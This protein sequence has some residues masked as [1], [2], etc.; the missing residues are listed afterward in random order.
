MFT[1]ITPRGTIKA[2]LILFILIVVSLKKMRK[3]KRMINDKFNN[4]NRTH[5]NRKKE[6]YLEHVIKLKG[7]PLNYST[8]LIDATRP[9]SNNQILIGITMLG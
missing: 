2:K 7:F 6:K 3:D 4:I 1:L 5:C 9:P 8:V